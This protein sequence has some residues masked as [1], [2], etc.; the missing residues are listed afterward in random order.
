MTTDKQWFENR[1]L[2]KEEHEHHL[3]QY[4]EHF[5]Q[6]LPNTMKRL[7]REGGGISGIGVTHGEWPNRCILIV[8]PLNG[9]FSEEAQLHLQAGLEY[10][11]EQFVREGGTQNYPPTLSLSTLNVLAT[12]IETALKERDT[13]FTIE[14]L[15]TVQYELSGVGRELEALLA[16]VKQEQARRPEALR[17]EKK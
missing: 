9:Y 7:I 12:W 15:S 6:S 5:A 8:P 2:T 13:A 14:S 4:Q 16:W 17:H 11:R 3:T 1:P 10:I